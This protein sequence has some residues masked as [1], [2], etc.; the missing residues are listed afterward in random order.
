MQVL[1]ECEENQSSRESEDYES[2]QQNCNRR[3]EVE[4]ISSENWILNAF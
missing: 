4:P 3:R 2:K 1:K